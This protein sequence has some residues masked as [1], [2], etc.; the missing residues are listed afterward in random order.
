MLLNLT[1]NRKNHQ[2]YGRQGV[3]V[4]WAPE[5]MWDVW[6][7]SSSSPSGIWLSNLL[8]AH[9]QGNHRFRSKVHQKRQKPH[10]CSP[11]PPPRGLR[12]KAFATYAT[13]QPGVQAPLPSPPPFKRPW[14]I[15]ILLRWQP[16]GSRKTEVVQNLQI[17]TQ[18]RVFIKILNY[19][20][21]FPQMSARM[22]HNSV[23]PRPLG[24]NS[25]IQH[26]LTLFNSAS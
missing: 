10:I 4:G 12:L 7:I 26:R 11:S 16:T 3:G 19:T 13:Q 9:S 23:G 1:G 25:R 14:T 17:I 6:F 22:I 18:G 15:I 24:F 20:S 2:S 5:Q 8:P 21:L